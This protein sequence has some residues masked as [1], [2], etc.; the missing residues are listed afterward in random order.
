MKNINNGLYRKIMHNISNSIYEEIQRFDVTDYED[1]ESN[2]IGT[3]TIH[4]LSQEYRY[5]PVT[6]KE[7]KIIIKQRIKENPQDPYLLDIDTS[8]IT[9]MFDLFNNIGL[10]IKIERLDLSTWDVS[11]VTNMSYMFYGC[12]LLKEVN[13][14]TWN[15]SHVTTMMAMF[16]DCKSLKSLDLTNFD[17][18]GVYNMKFMFSRC[19]S[20]VNLNI[21]NWNTS[22]V[23]DMIS[24]FNG[25]KSLKEL[26]LSNFNTYNV[27]Y[28]QA[29]FYGCK[30]L[31]KLNLTGWEIYNTR[32]KKVNMDNMFTGCNS[33]KTI[34]TDNS[35]IFYQFKLMIRGLNEK[36]EQFD[37]TDYS[38]NEDDFI[39]RHTITNVIKE[40]PSD[41]EE[42]CV[43][44]NDRHKNMENRYLDCSDIDVSNMGEDMNNLF[45][46]F[47][48]VETI[49]IT[50]WKT[51]NIENMS[52]MFYNCKNL[53]NIIGIGEL[54]L[55]NV[56]AI[57][58]MFSG[59][60]S[61]VSLDI[62]N[63]DVSNVG[64]MYCLFNE[65]KKLVSLNLSSWDVSSVYD[66]KYMF[67]NCYN[68]TNLY[69]SEWDVSGVNDMSF[70]FY[71]CKSLKSLDISNWNVQN[72]MDMDYMFYGCKLL[73]DMDISNWEPP[74]NLKGFYATFMFNNCNNY[75]NIPEWYKKYRE[76]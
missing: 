33:L 14:S 59:C 25:C 17:T 48:D 76:N 58:S 37:I 71:C 62:S 56:E 19:K 52:F 55:S 51:S 45:D 46:G 75:H 31:T 69:I 4:K 21:S 35:K 68:L 29:M 57:Q 63:W 32:K 36:M 5:F 54:N 67:Q 53:K 8:K 23:E 13:L 34:Q 1:G 38:D 42:L 24:M 49:N 3:S 11:N 22:K 40:H 26:D 2:I 60:E 9:D 66:M 12:T 28:M 16:E 65:C 39:D 50:G 47:N 15:T 18:S 74:I 44:I 43:L 27:K 20:L 64:N 6:N 30:L 10:K 73:S 41:Y 72:T 7:L 70:M 61:L